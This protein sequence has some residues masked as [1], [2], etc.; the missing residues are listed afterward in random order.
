MSFEKRG[1]MPLTY[2]AVCYPGSPLRFRGP[3]AA[4]SAP[5]VLC[6]GGSETFGR[7]IHAPYAAQLATKLPCH[8]VNM[9]VMNAGLDVLMH[10]PAIT[11]AT[12]GAAAVV[13]Q[14]TGAQNLSNRLYRVHPRRNDRFVK[15][16]AMLRT[17]YRDVDFTEFHF[18]R[19]LLTHL[20]DRSPERFGIVAAELQ[21]AWMA[22]MR[23]FL[24]RINVPVHLLWL[25]RRHPEDAVTTYGL[26]PDPLFV[27]PNMLAEVAGMAA[28]LSIISPGDPNVALS[29]RGMFFGIREE[30]AARVLPGPDLHDRAANALCALLS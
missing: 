23:S 28:S 11:R 15:T 9:G 6:L 5:F 29:T 21:I 3:C 18:T 7:F 4:M 10:D 8:V 17:I 19:H 14:I 25:A 24:G 16:T 20:H 27:T 22:R 26:G 12:Q 13:L 30:A 1:P 2:D